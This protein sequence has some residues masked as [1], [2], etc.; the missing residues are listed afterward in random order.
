MVTHSFDVR[1]ACRY[2]MLEAVLFENIRFWIAKNEANGVHFHDG[3]YWTYNSSKAFA[4]LFP[5][6]SP[7]SIQRALRR[8]VDVG[9]LRTG[10][11]NQSPYDRT[12]WY[13][14][15]AGNVGIA[16]EDGLASSIGQKCPIEGSDV[17]HGNSSIVQPIP[18]IKP[19]NKQSPLYPPTGDDEPRVEDDGSEDADDDG[20]RQPVSD[21]ASPSRSVCLA[22]GSP[23]PESS[24]AG[25]AAHAVSD[26]SEAQA[27][28]DAGAVA[29]DVGSDAVG[30]VAL[31]ASL[32]DKA[33]VVALPPFK[34]EASRRR[35]EGR[36][37]LSAARLVA[38]FGLSRVE[39][40]ARWALDVGQ[41]FW[42]S[43]A[44]TPERLERHWAQV[45]SQ[46]TNPVAR[47]GRSGCLPAGVDGDVKSHKHSAGC[48]H[49]QRIL[50]YTDAADCLMDPRSWRV[51]HWLEDGEDEQ[52][53]RE[54]LDERVW[55][56]A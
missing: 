11:Y 55:E 3:C 4:R 50:G 45:T 15:G 9:L 37:R 46:M 14:L 13:A 56:V 10:N 12:L 40:A 33:P 8:L 24:S 54:L 34:S 22:D 23:Q 41:P 32:R 47:A 27:V 51:L 49:V 28:P 7:R 48:A 6:A 26:A 30:V 53:I 44:F 52:K 16:D 42:R 21:L 31:M 25:C 36:Q 18:D 19:D 2:G 38:A 43:V 1:V 29:C 17:T 35:F 20:D 5:Y 39:Q